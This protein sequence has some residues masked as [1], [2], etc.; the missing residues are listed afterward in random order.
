MTDTRLPLRSDSLVDPVVV[1]R[2]NADTVFL[3]GVQPSGTGGYVATAVAPDDHPYYAAHTAEGNRRLD[4]M[5][6]LEACRQGLIYLGHTV[7]E[8]PLD[9]R[10]LLDTCALDI[11]A[12]A[13][14][15]LPATGACELTMAVLDVAAQRTGR[16][17]RSLAPVFALSA[18]DVQIGRVE[19]GASLASPAAY[20]ALRQRGRSGPPSY[21][22]EL[23][24]PDRAGAVPPAE[25]G[26][27][28]PADVLL[29]D[30]RTTGDGAEARVLVPGGHAGLFDHP[31]DHIPGSLLV[32]AARQLGTTMSPKP[33][34]AVMTGMTAVF[35]AFAELEVPV[36]L[37]ARTAT[38]DNEVVV[39]A[40]QGDTEVAT[41][42]VRTRGQQAS[43]L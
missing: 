19:V 41:V 31:L 18:G 24:D 36:Q 32:E 34:D 15:G 40:R 30:L 1:H 14:R 13:Y 7:C 23:P 26:R 39:T 37:R 42:T 27:V 12:D 29:A 17:V 28:D 38:A 33:A 22:D 5:L 3:T 9:T 2:R 35:H 25:V 21:S 43:Y 16:R 11:S 20:A 4:P 10:F 8:A 6:L